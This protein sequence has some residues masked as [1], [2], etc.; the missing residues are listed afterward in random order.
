MAEIIG[1]VTARFDNAGLESALSDILLKE[2][3]R[4][5]DRMRNSIKR[6]IRTVL[7]NH[8]K[9]HPII[10]SIR[11]LGGSNSLQAEFG[12]TD[13]MAA[14]ASKLIVEK[15]SQVPTASIIE[16]K[17]G[18]TSKVEISIVGLESFDLLEKLDIDQEP[19]EYISTGTGK[20]SKQRRIRWMRIVVNPR[21]RL[22]DSY[23]PDVN[24]TAEDGRKYELVKGDFTIQ[25]KDGDLVGRSFSRSGLATMKLRH[26]PKNFPYTIPK[27]VIPT[28]RNSINFIDDIVN[29]RSF[30][31][32]VRQI[33]ADVV[34][35]EMGT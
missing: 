14:S 8:L 32:Q 17:I 19:F 34:Q 20:N 1:K 16:K 7:K 31:S 6:R 30:T 3:R 29:S 10:R 4:R 12:L 9:K 18:T 21:P 27:I 33:V 26:N 5:K 22:I 13:D 2:S 11:G 23:F 35:R 15:I 25:N 24:T 28:G